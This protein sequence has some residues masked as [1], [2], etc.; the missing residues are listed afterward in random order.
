MIFGIKTTSD[1]SK[2]SQI[3]LAYKL[4]K[5][6]ITILKYHLWYLCQ[7]PLLIMLLPILTLFKLCTARGSAMAARRSTPYNGLY[8]RAPPATG[9]SFRLQ[10]YE[11]VGATLV[12]VYERTRKSVIAVC[13]WTKKRY[14]EGGPSLSKMVYKTIRGWISGRNLPSIRFCSVPPGE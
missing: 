1:I 7:I 3:S 11:R 6:R 5:L 14:T 12:E 2:L 10:I 8:G 13:E 4:V 9:T